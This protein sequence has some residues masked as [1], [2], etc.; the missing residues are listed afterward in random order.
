MTETPP[1]RARRR[2][3]RPPREFVDFASVPEHQWP[4]HDRLE[5][6]ARAQRGGDKQS[7]SAAPIF[8]LHKS[9]EW[10][11][12]E[13]GA[14]TALSVDRSDAVLVAKGVIALPEKHRAALQWYYIRHGSNPMGKR[15]ELG[16]TLRDLA[17]L[18]IDA[19][20]MLINRR[21]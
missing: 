15:A 8:K 19:R 12:R 20:Q 2:E 5:N 13:Y 11:S 1:T 17:Q 10:H 9:D 21:I 4:M 18:V 6:W 14:E 7:G 3:P 16:V